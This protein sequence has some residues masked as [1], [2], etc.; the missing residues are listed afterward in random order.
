MF[1]YNILAVSPFQLRADFPQLAINAKGSHIPFLHTVFTNPLVKK[2][3]NIS[4]MSNVCLL[5]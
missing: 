4:E 5:V 3:A 1:L 2:N